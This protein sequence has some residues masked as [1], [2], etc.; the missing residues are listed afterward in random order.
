LITIISV[1]RVKND[2]TLGLGSGSRRIS[3]SGM[4]AIKKKCTYKK[5][6]LLSAPTKKKIIK[7]KNTKK[8]PFIL[9]TY[10]VKNNSNKV[11]Y[12]VS[13]NLPHK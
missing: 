1:T 7:K 13:N 2:T 12:K 9:A 8:N 5:N 10:Y 11:F 3:S 6:T 4:T